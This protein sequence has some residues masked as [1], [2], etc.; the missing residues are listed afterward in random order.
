MS[1][2]CQTSCKAVKAAYVYMYSCQSGV[3]QQFLSSVWCCQGVVS[4][5]F[6][7]FSIFHRRRYPALPHYFFII[8]APRG[9][10]THRCCSVRPPPPPIIPT[11]QPLARSLRRAL[12][13]F[14]AGFGASRVTAHSPT[15]PPAHISH[16]FSFK[17]LTFL[18]VL[19]KKL[20]IIDIKMI[21]PEKVLRNKHG[22]GGGGG[23]E[24]CTDPSLPFSAKKQYKNK[25]S[26]A[27][28]Y[29]HSKIRKGKET[30]T[31][32]ILIYK[33]CKPN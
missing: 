6:W 21:G 27:K 10:H 25:P 11:Q 4:S 5:I 1:Q 18:I 33:W 23:Q 16:H 28:V 12:Q 2:T 26:F 32:A 30:K 15:H 19:A 14:R 13:G 20:F 17:H 8:D 31:K 7:F 29:S 24:E 22:R 3:P 9:A